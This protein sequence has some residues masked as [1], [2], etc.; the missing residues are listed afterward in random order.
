EVRGLLVKETYPNHNG[1]ASPGDP[2][3]GIVEYEHDGAGRM[4]RRTDQNG[5]TVTMRFDLAGRAYQKDY[6]TEAEGPTGAI[7]DSVMLTHDAS[8]RVLTAHSERY[9]N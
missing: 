8:S 4:F 6:R 1:M 2:D 5:D 3:Y 7:A 9:D